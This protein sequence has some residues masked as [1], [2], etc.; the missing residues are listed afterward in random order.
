ML[1][2]RKV[3]GKS[4][5]NKQQ[6]K[7]QNSF[8]STASSSTG[9]TPSTSTPTTPTSG[10]FIHDNRGIFRT[11]EPVWYY[12][13]YSNQQQQQQQ[14]QQ[15][16]NGNDGSDSNSD[17]DTHQ[18]EQGMDW[19]QF[20]SHCQTVLEVAYRQNKASCDLGQNCIVHFTAAKDD[21]V[22]NETVRRVVAPVWWFEQDSVIDGS[23]GM[24]RFDYKNQ[25]RLEALADEDRSKLSLVDEA[26]PHPFTITLVPKSRDQREEWRGFLHL[27]FPAVYVNSQH[28][29][30]ASPYDSSK[31]AA[32]AMDYFYDGSMASYQQDDYYA[33]STDGAGRR[34]SI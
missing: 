4:K 22:L 5:R 19:V 10:P 16:P 23:K 7:K 2:I 6:K 24:C 28:N 31:G 17:N 30:L 15:D 21:W 14:Q 26:F 18:V 27:E 29:L 25:A 20:D 12:G 11:L 9:S 13:Y 33:T 34:F 1:S 32:L 3:F 8:V